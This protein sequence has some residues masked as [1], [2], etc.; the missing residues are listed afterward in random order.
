MHREGK[1]MIRIRSSVIRVATAVAAAT[2][3]TAGCGAGAASSGVSGAKAADRGNH[4]RQETDGAGGDG[5]AAVAAQ[6]QAE[7]AAD[8][9]VALETAPSEGARSANATGV[10]PGKLKGRSGTVTG[11]VG[12][13][14]APVPGVQSLGSTGTKVRELQARL[15]QLGLFKLNPTGYFGPI[16]QR[17]VLAFQRAH[18]VPTTGNAG[19]L[20]WKALKARTKAP[21]RDQLYPVTTRPVAKPDKRC[22]TGRV[23]CISKQSRTLTWMVDGKV[24]GAMDVRFGAQYTPTREGSFTVFW[25]SR[26]HVSSIYHTPMPYA[27][28]F[29]GGQAVHYSSDFAARGYNG[30]SHGCVN[31]RDKAKLASLFE[32]VRTGDRVV[33]YR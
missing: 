26:D 32:Q 33:V 20:T 1:Q 31:V 8:Q 15:L 5:A 12:A 16:T 19:P 3:L 9:E 22:L 11:A 7:R 13:V 18:G 14:A 23:L 28:F 24:R 30:A 4:T 29:S 21:T 10:P 27:M 25:K 6:R 17:S 2:A